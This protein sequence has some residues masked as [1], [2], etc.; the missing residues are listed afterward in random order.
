MMRLERRRSPKASSQSLPKL[1][2]PET[3]SNL[4]LTPNR[5]ISAECF[6]NRNQ[7]GN[8]QGLGGHELFL[9]VQQRAFR[10]KHAE[11]VGDTIAVAL[12]RKFD[13]FGGRMFG[14]REIREALAFAA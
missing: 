6:V 3:S 2:R 10:V 5:R 12:A 1:T 14:L 7:A 13:G 9:Q 8:R 4:G 11:V